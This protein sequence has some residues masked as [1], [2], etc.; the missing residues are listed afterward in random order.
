MK[1]D[2][3]AG[4]SDY[5]FLD[6]PGHPKGPEYELKEFLDQYR[7]QRAQPDL[8]SEPEQ[9]TSGHKASGVVGWEPGHPGKGMMVH[10]VPHTWCVDQMYQPNHSE[11]AKKIGLGGRSFGPHI[12]I[13]PDGTIHPASLMAGDD[14]SPFLEADSRLKAPTLQSEPQAG[15]PTIDDLGDMDFE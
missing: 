11:Y 14:V 7:D 9:V 2:K 4:M 5:K 10:G 3:E 6:G 1:A 8:P 12:V 15:A 13:N